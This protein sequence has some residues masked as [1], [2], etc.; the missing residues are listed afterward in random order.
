MT[1]K[2]EVFFRNYLNK[3]PLFLRIYQVKDLKISKNSKKVFSDQMQI[4][5]S[6]FVECK[7]PLKPISRLLTFDEQ[8]KF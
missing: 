2:K 1:N 4:Y 3:L 7:L 8:K 5:H 6:E